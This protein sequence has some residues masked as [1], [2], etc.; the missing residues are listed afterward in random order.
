MSGT[1]F[2]RNRWRHA[3]VVGVLALASPL[4]AQTTS[5]DP[6]PLDERLS[7]FLQFRTAALSR[8]QLTAPAVRERLDVLPDVL[9]TST[10]ALT[11]Y[12]L[13]RAVLTDSFKEFLQSADKARVDQQI[14]STSKAVKTGVAALVGFAIE[15]GAV[16]QTI[17]QNVATL[18]ANAEGVGRFLSNQDVFA[19]CAPDDRGCNAWSALKNLELSASFNVSDADTRTL[20]GTSAATPR[21]VTVASTFT[22]H[23]FASATARYAVVNPRDLRSKKYQQQWLLWFEA[24]RTQLQAAGDRLL[25][26]LTD[27]TIKLQQVDALGRPTTGDSQYSLWLDRTRAALRPFETADAAA[28]ERWMKTLQVQ[29]DELLDRMRRVDPDFDR[30]LTELGKEYV[31]YLAARRDLMA[32]LVTDPA[33]TL[34]YTYAEPQ[35]QP[36]LHTLKVAWAYSPKSDPGLPNP[37]TISVNGGLDYYHDAQ[38]TGI[39][40]NTSHWKDAQVAVQFDRPLGPAGSA[41]IFSASF[42][43]QYQMNPNTFVVPAAGLTLVSQ[44]G[45]IAVAQ[46]TL[47]IRMAS[48]GL[49]IPIGVSWANRT[50]LEPGNKFIGHIGFTFDASPLLLMNALK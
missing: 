12:A 37:G 20:T 16:S 43:Y 48:S 40:L 44:A 10:Q 45:S 35:L 21:P 39:G 47:T 49:R 3:V 38:P 15:T 24:N 30:K 33:L 7:L 1:R 34:E 46:A 2:M 22:R 8:G 26:H 4:A 42:Y 28:S 6:R 41:A 23:Q 9:G 19:P 29:L 31:R 17:D 32:T 18:R 11:Y 50:E 13:P 5:S 25:A 14:G 36:R 27:V